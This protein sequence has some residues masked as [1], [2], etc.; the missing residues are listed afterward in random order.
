MAT[1]P[2]PQLLITSLLET[3]PIGI[4]VLDAECRYLHINALLAASNGLPAAAHIGQ[5]PRD[6]LPDAGPGL[7]TIMQ[8]VLASNQARTRFAA[9]AE[10]PPGSGKLR[11]WEASYHPLPGRDGQPAGIIAMVEDVTVRHEA[12]RLQ[13]ENDAHVRRVLDNLFTFVGVLSPDGTLHSANRAPLEAAGIRM[14]DVYGLKFWDCYWWSYA[15]HVQAQLEHAVMQAACGEVSRFDVVVRM[16]GDSRLPIDFMLAPLRDEHGQITHLIASAIDISA[17]KRSEDALRQN[18]ALL[19]EVV[20]AIPDGLMMI[21]S[22]GLI[23]LVNQRMES[24]FGYPRATLLGQHFDYL[25]PE[26]LRESHRARVQHYMQAPASRDIASSQVLQARRRDGSL[27]PCE[28]GLTPLLVGGK[29][30]VLASITDITERYQARQ[31]IEQALQEKTALLGEVHHRVNDNLQVIS[32][33]LQLQARHASAEVQAALADSQNHV[34]AMAL[35]HQLLYE[36]KDFAHLPL[37]DY[38]Y[39]LLQLLQPAHGDIRLHYQP[40]AKEVML[41]MS[42]GIPLGLLVSELISNAIHHAFASGLG[43]IYLDLQQDG[44]TTCLVVRDNGCG[45][46]AGS[47]PGPGRSL[48]FQMLPLLAQ[49]LHASLECDTPPGGGT[50]FTL[51]FRVAAATATAGGTPG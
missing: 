26:T 43:D 7:E 39:R 51:R 20:E 34:R 9:C 28:I 40:A 25:L 1:E 15:P 19:R 27:F 14:S 32:N 23:R 16:A 49:L 46:P 44:D 13:R 42:Q 24:L 21:D 33:L 47:Y 48:G 38:L 6:V 12:E 11:H 50:R 37:G 18:E 5:R 31:A 45:L 36:R 29:P 3:A 17:R 41:A 8:A 4:A 22:Q 10:I 2:D 35:I 30:H